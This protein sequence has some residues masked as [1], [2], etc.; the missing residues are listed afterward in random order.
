M[1]TK[2]IEKLNAILIKRTGIDFEKRIDLQNEKMFGRRI[3]LPPREL[4]LIL[5]DVEKIFEV[6]I[7]DDLL[8]GGE[9]NSYIGIK[10][11]LSRSLNETN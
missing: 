3:N 4:V 8:I 5:N 9:F 6:R 11:C 2:N 10:K 1:E 7:K